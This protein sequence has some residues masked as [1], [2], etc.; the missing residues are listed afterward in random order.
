MPTV[1]KEKLKSVA[2]VSGG[3]TASTSLTPWSSTVTVQVSPT[4]KSVVG[5][6]VYVVVPPEST[7]GCAPLDVHEIVNVALATRD[8]LAEA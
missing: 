6:S 5:S 3:S 2:M 1:E 7:N 4:A 8:R